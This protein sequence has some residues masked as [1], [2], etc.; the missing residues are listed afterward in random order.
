MAKN[1]IIDLRNHLFETI[2]RLKDGDMEIDKARA[3]AEVAQIIVN[4]AKVEVE[5]I[6]VSS[7]DGTGFIE[8]THK[9]L[10]P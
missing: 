7:G 9:T 4:T 1:K 8:D 10:N 5:F 2:E 6:K 3:I